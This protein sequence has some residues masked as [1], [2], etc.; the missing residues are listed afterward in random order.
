MKT[1][2]FENATLYLGD[3]LE[4][5]AEI[6]SVDSVITDPPYG[7]G[8]QYNVHDDDWDSYADFIWPRIEK[9]ESLVSPGGPIFVWQAQKRI[10][11]FVKFFPRDWRL[12]IAA[13]NFVQIRPGPM[14]HSYD[15]VVV[16]WKPGG[17]TWTSPDNSAGVNR[18]YYV[19]NSAAAV[20]D[21]KSLARQHPCPRPLDQVKY[22]VAN[23]CKP[24]STVLDCF[25]GSGTTGV[26]CSLLGRKFIGIEKDPQYFDLARRRIEDAQKQTS[27]FG[28]TPDT[29]SEM[30]IESEPA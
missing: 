11:E 27:L 22:I 23:W 1:E 14:N 4:A 5:M 2:R 6:E 21:T 9:A 12:F 3:C 13:K 16:W 30:I 28:S 26:A 24:A 10:R 15:P 18:D 17:D 20:S 7:I 25:M 8:F 29:Q 19:S